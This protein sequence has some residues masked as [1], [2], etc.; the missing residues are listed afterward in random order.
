MSNFTT[1]TSQPTTEE[2]WTASEK[3]L[4]ER[5]NKNPGN[6]DSELPFIK[7]VLDVKKAGSIIK[8]NKSLVIAT[9]VLCIVTLLGFLG[10]VIA[11]IYYITK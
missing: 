11:N 2:Y 9:W 4:L 8:T 1:K 5:L 3:E 10:G 7:T 6:L